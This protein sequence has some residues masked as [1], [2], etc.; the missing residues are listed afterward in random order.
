M[1][2]HPKIGQEVFINYKDKSMPCQGETGEVVAVGNGKGPK[3][4]LVLFADSLCAIYYFDVIP[5]GNLNER[6]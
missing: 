5:R 6:H 3:N 4:A 1:I 2:W